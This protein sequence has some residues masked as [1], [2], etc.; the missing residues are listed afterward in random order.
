MKQSISF[1]N[2]IKAVLFLGISFSVLLACTEPVKEKKQND[3]TTI[4]THNTSKDNTIFD[5]L[6]RWNALQVED[7]NEIKTILNVETMYFSIDSDIIKDGSSHI[8]IYPALNKN[9]E[10][11]FNIVTSNEDEDSNYI[12]SSSRN[13]YLNSLD[14]N[15]MNFAR[16]FD[17]NNP[18]SPHHISTQ[19]A[20]NRVNHWNESN[21][22]NAWISNRVN[23]SSCKGSEVDKLNPVFSILV[24][25]VEDFKPLDKHYSILAINNSTQ[26]ADLIVVNT[27]TSGN[28]LT[29]VSQDVVR[30][31]PPCKPATSPEDGDFSK[32]KLLQKVANKM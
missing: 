18:N 3:S 27:S 2:L 11:Y 24:M 22:R 32:F 14:S 9:K 19:H 20:Y 30:S 5:D 21:S 4:S 25:N 31:I 29:Y 16:Y 10:L 1:K 8:H 13:K 23:A 28:D 17:K 12:L 6:M 26:S 15:E 7:S